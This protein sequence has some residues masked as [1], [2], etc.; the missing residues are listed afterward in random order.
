MNLVTADGDTPL[1]MAAQTKSSPMPLVELLCDRRANLEARDR[2]TADTPLQRVV[3][4]PTQ[5]FGM[6]EYLIRRGASVHTTS[7]PAALP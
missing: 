2:R 7:E 1:H 6:A 3:G 4:H 5:S